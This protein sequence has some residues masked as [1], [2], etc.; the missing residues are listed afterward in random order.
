MLNLI[1]NFFLFIEK[2]PKYDICSH[3]SICKKLDYLSENNLVYMM[4]NNFGRFWNLLENKNPNSQIELIDL[5]F[6]IFNN[7]KNNKDDKDDK[8]NIKDSN[9][10]KKSLLDIVNKLIKYSDNINLI[11]FLSEF[12]NLDEYESLNLIKKYYIENPNYNLKYILNPNYDFKHSENSNYNFKHS[13]G[14]YWLKLTDS[15]KN[16][17]L[18][19]V[20]KYFDSLDENEKNIIL[21]IDK[22]NTNP[23]PKMT[24]DFFDSCKPNVVIIKCLDDYNKLMSIIEEKETKTKKNTLVDTLIFEYINFKDKQ[25]EI[26]FKIKNLKIRNCSLSNLDY[27][28]NG[29]IVLDCFGNK[30]TQLD[31]LPFGLKILLCG[32]NIIQQLDN[33]PNSLEYLDCHTNKIE[34]FKSLPTSLK[35][36]KCNC[37]DIS[38]LGTLPHNL[39]YLSCD[40]NKIKSLENLPS[41][42]IYLSCNK[43]K[44]TNVND[45]PLG[46]KILNLSKNFIREIHSLNSN[47]EEIDLSYNTG[48]ILFDIPNM[49]TKISYN[50]VLFSNFEIQKLYTQCIYKYIFN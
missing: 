31:N 14:M 35:Y 30:I 34:T 15:N 38:D 33:L 16:K 21:N 40:G 19:M 2:V 43:N 22:I 29:L 41:K 25:I 12:Y 50:N 42:L 9:E 11:Q 46:L 28:H 36:L 48:I 47:I 20:E 37:N 32:N 10:T 8:D 45:L 18:T 44:I 23:N 49:I 7:Y 27:L 24:I 6:S 13:F 5:F 1:T 4:R 17:L 3:L 39:I 26:P